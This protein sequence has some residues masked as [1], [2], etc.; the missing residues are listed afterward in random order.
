MPTQNYPFSGE[1]WLC[2][3]NHVESYSNWYISNGFVSWVSWFK[4]KHSKGPS[5]EKMLGVHMLKLDTI[6]LSSRAIIEHSCYVVAAMDE[7]HGCLGRNRNRSLWSTTEQV[8]D[9][10]ITLRR[11]QLVA[12]EPFKHEA[13][14]AATGRKTDGSEKQS[15]E[16]TNQVLA[17]IMFHPDLPFFPGLPSVA[18]SWDRFEITTRCS[19]RLAACWNGP[20]PSSALPC[21]GCLV[22]APGLCQQMVNK[23]QVFCQAKKSQPCCYKDVVTWNKIIWIVTYLCLFTGLL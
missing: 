8:M 5:L 12:V 3:Y 6:L 21:L 2:W 13:A 19:G 1:A 9:L 22:M 7:T 18:P 20:R 23:K 10:K 17:Y 15:S 4:I 14:I 11:S 16:T